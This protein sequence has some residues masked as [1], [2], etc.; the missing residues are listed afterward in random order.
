VTSL[1]P[2]VPRVRGDKG[3][4]LPV[5]EK[6]DICRFTSSYTDGHQTVTGLVRNKKR[7][8]RSFDS[9]VACDVEAGGRGSGR[10]QLGAQFFFNNYIHSTHDNFTNDRVVPLRLKKVNKD[11]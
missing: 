10:A 8:V 9:D 6:F 3:R 11:I 1:Y 4:S 7:T 2:S 5:Y